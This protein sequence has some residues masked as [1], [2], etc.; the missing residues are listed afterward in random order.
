[1][2]IFVDASHTERQGQTDLNLYCK[3]YTQSTTSKCLIPIAESTREFNEARA[4]AELGNLEVVDELEVCR[5]R[6]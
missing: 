6:H 4:M 3:V 1:M 5:I 2:K